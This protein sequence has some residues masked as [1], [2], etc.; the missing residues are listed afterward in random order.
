M[1]VDA[2]L[3]SDVH[4]GSRG[5]NVIE[6]CKVLREYT[7]SEIIIIGDFIDGWLFGGE[8]LTVKF[9]DAVDGGVENFDGEESIR[10]ACE[11]FKEDVEMRKM[12]LANLVKYKMT[13]LFLKE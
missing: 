8:P 10:R 7:P 1:N 9:E 3:I 4:I 6:L 11:Y 2:L 5:S 13:H 12:Q